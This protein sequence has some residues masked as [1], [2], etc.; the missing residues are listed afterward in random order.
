M[1]A[2]FVFNRLTMDDAQFRILNWG[3]STNHRVVRHSVVGGYRTRAL[4]D[5]APTMTI[6]GLYAPAGHVS[7]GGSPPTRAAT[8]NWYK[9]DLSAWD[10][11]RGTTGEFITGRMSYGMWTLESVE[12]D[13]QQLLLGAGGGIAPR[14]VSWT[15]SFVAD[16]ERI[17]V[18]SLPEP[19]PPP[20][21]EEV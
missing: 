11:L 7:L 6:G 13:H 8:D 5:E 17:V 21:P 12:Y 16:S 15:M 20:G 14:L 3:R 18:D 4:G 10:A 2:L 9:P 19:D 1:V